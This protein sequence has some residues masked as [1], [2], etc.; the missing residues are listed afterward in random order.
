[1]WFS[2]SRTT[3]QVSSF[4]SLHLATSKILKSLEELWL[5]WQYLSRQGSLQPV[6]W[7]SRQP[8]DASGSRAS[9]HLN[10]QSGWAVR[11]ASARQPSASWT[12]KE[13]R[14]F[15]YTFI[16]SCPCNYQLYLRLSLAL[17]RDL[18]VWV[19]ETVTV[20]KAKYYLI[21]HYSLKDFSV[22]LISAL[23]RSSLHSRVPPGEDTSRLP[24][25]DPKAWIAK[26]WTRGQ[27]F[28]PESYPRM[29]KNYS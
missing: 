7:V 27:L 11:A 8:Q 14:H 1:M 22:T 29:R 15:F 16:H 23:Q 2:S 26:V 25:A 18:Y 5:G 13:N 3:G 17:Y 6:R 10:T 19:W 9:P 28:C 4:L 24:R 21:V 12:I 20:L